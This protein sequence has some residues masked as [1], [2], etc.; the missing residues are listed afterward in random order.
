MCYGTSVCWIRSL[1]SVLTREFNGKLRY[2]KLCATCVLLQNYWTQTLA[3]SSSAASTPSQYRGCYN[4][5]CT[6]D[7]QSQSCQTAN[8]LTV[9]YVHA[10]LIFNGTCLTNNSFKFLFSAHVI[11]L[12]VLR[13]LVLQQCVQCCV[14][15]NCNKRLLTGGATSN[16][17]T[18]SV[19]AMAVAVATALLL[20][21]H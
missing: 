15:N 10:R 9:C 8:G 13:C 20:L 12:P 16:H 14:G 4:Q 17:V 21:R 2:S 5:T 19:T 3:T 1:Q 6:A 7:L 11:H 18:T